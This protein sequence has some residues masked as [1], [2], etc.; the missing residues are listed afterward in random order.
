MT[1][2]R[3]TMIS[4][5]AAQAVPLP[6]SV[7]EEYT[8]STSGA[9]V[10]QPADRPSMMAFFAKS[11]ELYEIMNDILLSLYM[12]VPDECAEDMYGFYFSQESKEGER[13]IFEL[14]RALTKWSRSLPPHLRKSSVDASK[15]PIFYRQGIVIRAR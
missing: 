12:P 5:C 8:Y 7:D 2:G 10:C 11:V 14:D 4:K 6:A 13:T 1:F 9:E 3:P 15:N